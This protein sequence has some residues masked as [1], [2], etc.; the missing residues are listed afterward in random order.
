MKT[1]RDWLQ[2][3]IAPTAGLIGGFLYAAGVFPQNSEVLIFF[4]ALIG[5][6]V[7]GLAD[8]RFNGGSR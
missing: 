2:F 6:P 4:A 1:Y 5:V 3:V 7:F 8:R